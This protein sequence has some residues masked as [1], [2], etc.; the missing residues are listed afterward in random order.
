MYQQ[1]DQLHEAANADG[2]PVIVW[3][4]GDAKSQAAAYTTAFEQ[5]FPEIGIEV[6]VGLSKYLDVEIDRCRCPGRAVRHPP[7]RSAITR[8]RISGTRRI[9]GLLQIAP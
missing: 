1:I 3:A 7:H 2:G 5:R 9:L 4:G 6:T 8:I